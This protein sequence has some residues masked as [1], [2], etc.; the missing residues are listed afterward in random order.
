MRGTDDLDMLR[1]CAPPV[2]IISISISIS[3]QQSI[4]RV[5]EVSSPR[6]CPSLRTTNRWLLSVLR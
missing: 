3:N 1:A 6:R 5:G 4:D 2:N